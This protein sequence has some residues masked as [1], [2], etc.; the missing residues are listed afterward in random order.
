MPQHAEPLDLL[1]LH[2]H[3]MLGI[4]AAFGA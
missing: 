3:P 4:G 2:I 1:T